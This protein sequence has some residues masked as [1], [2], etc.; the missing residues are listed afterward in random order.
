[1]EFRAY[2]AVD[3]ANARFAWGL[4]EE[5]PKKAEP[6]PEGPVGDPGPTSGAVSS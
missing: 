1:M 6:L 5:K 2:T 4:S 3:V